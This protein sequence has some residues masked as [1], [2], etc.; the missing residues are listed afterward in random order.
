MP[1]FPVATFN[2]QALANVYC[3]GDSL[4]ADR[5]SKEAIKRRD[6]AGYVTSLDH[7][8]RTG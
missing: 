2:H 5:L 8:W 6:T 3:N 7:T 1:P 4:K